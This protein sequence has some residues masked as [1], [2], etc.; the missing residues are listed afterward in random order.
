MTR[1][2]DKELIESIPSDQRDDF[3]FMQL[4]NLWTV[5]GLYFLG[6]EEQYGTEV[7]TQIDANV[8][9]IMGKIEARKLKEFFRPAIM[10]IPTV[11]RLLEFT[12][13]ALDLED[14]EV[15]LHKDHAIVRNRQC[16]VQTTRISK[17]FSEFGCKPVRFGFLQA[18][19]KEL[20]PNITVTCHHCPPDAH[21]ADNWCEWELRSKD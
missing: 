7:A 15:E 17:G 19:V 9:K 13:W 5:D 14:K 10:D 6:I 21:P 12:G 3:L 1:K 18:F 16:R 2:R 4:R 20:N 8:W 11:L